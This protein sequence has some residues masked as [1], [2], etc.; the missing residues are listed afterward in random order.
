MTRYNVLK[1]HDQI[2]GPYGFGI[3]GLNHLMLLLY[4]LRSEW[5]RSAEFAVVAVCVDID[6][7]IGACTYTWSTIGVLNPSQYHLNAEYATI[8]GF[9][10]FAVQYFCDST[11]RI[12]NVF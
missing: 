5:L 12:W 7:D 10:L 3:E 2:D 4:F 11:R 6:I 9:V 8:P 1:E